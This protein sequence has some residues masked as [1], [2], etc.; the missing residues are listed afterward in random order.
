LYFVYLTVTITSGSSLSIAIFIVAFIQM[1]SCT[2]WL[3]F[4]YGIVICSAFVLV[5]PFIAIKITYW[6]MCYYATT[7]ISDIVTLIVNVFVLFV[8]TF[9]L[10]YTF[11]TVLL[12]YSLNSFIFMPI[13]MIV[14]VLW[15][16]TVIKIVSCIMSVI[17]FYFIIVGLIVSVCVSFVGAVTD[18]WIF[19]GL[20]LY[21]CPKFV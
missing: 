7:T 17:W 10:V 5:L 12:I 18:C 2:N 4:I 20:T 21:S 16:E 3:F 13:V 9:V 8:K 19:L 1:Y 6:L 11:I 15:L 14:F